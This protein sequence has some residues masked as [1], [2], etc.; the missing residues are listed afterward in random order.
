[1]VIDPFGRAVRGFGSENDNDD[2]RRS[3]DALAAI[4]ITDVIASWPG[5]GKG[6]VEEFAALID[7]YRE[8]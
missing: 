5:S 6:R 8:A 7:D 4:G 1:M 3:L 2:V